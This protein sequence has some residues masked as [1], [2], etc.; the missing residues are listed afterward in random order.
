M[1]IPSI[2]KEERGTYYCIAENGVSPADQRSIGIEVEFLPVVTA[3]KILYFQTV[4]HDADLDCK[5]EAYP[6]PA[7][8][9][10]KDGIQLLNNQRYKYV[11]FLCVFI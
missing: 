2:T 6:P 8:V 4:M 7:I 11:Y 1:Y 10:I 3:S 5:I 9:W